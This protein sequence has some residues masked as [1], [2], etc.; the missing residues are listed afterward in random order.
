MVTAS[1]VR[2]KV[3]APE[4]T[5][6]LL[7]SL[8]LGAG[9]LVSATSAQAAGKS[10]PH[11]TLELISENPWVAA[12]HWVNLGLR[13]ELEKGWHIYWINPGDSG[14]PPHV[15]WQLP[16]GFT[17]GET[18]WPAPRRLGASSVVD[19]GYEDAVTLIVPLRAGTNVA[20]QK[21]AQLAAEVR[22]LVCRE[23]CIPGRHNFL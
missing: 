18:K 3:W 15:Q 10:I 2:A 6:T 22:V 5:L 19:F 21:R 14:E 9:L 12:G 16:A 20:S 17:V 7:P 23:M 8:L 11:G 4:I 1:F 13:F